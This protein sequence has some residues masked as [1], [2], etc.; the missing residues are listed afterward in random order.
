MHGVVT[1]LSSDD[2]LFLLDEID[3]EKLPLEARKMALELRSVLVKP[4]SVFSSRNVV[5]D[6][7]VS[8]SPVGVFNSNE[9]VSIRELPFP[10][11]DSEDAQSV[12]CSAQSIYFPQPQDKQLLC[13]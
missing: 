4:R 1:P 9:I 13:H 3:L 10:F 11:R 12:Q 2:M 5:F 6:A 7:D 8:V